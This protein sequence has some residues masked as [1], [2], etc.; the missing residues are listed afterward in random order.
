MAAFERAFPTIDRPQLV[1]A[2]AYPTLFGRDLC[3]P[4]P[5][6]LPHANPDPHCR[7][8]ANPQPD[9]STEGHRLLRSFG[10]SPAYSGGA[11]GLFALGVSELPAYVIESAMNP[12]TIRSSPSVIFDGGGF[13]S[14]AHC[15]Y[16]S[17][18]PRAC[19][20]P[21]FGRGRRQDVFV[22]DMLRSL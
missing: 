14:A 8:I 20:G 12:Q 15:A 22:D 2:A 17:G 1:K 5:R 18:S 3:A 6:G 7:N 4:L 10:W 9:H 16:V 19:R 11:R 21:E 13:A